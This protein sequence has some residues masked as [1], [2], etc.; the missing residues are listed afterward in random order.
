MQRRMV[1]RRPSLTSLPRLQLTL[2]F[3]AQLSKEDEEAVGDETEVRRE[4]QDKINKF[5]R[6][7]QRELKYEEELRLKN[8]WGTS[9]V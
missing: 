7:H 8:V 6:L 3:L 1:C 9:S 4:D 5:S 2:P